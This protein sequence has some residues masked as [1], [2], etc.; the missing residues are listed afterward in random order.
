[1]LSFFFFRRIRFSLPNPTSSSYYQNQMTKH[2]HK[3]VKKIPFDICLSSIHPPVQLPIYH[4]SPRPRVGINEYT[5][6][7][8][9]KVGCLLGSKF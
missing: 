2:F 3:Y 9:T 1:M 5:V 8:D 6:Y 7:R 4:F